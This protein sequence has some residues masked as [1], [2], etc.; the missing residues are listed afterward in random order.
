MF[1]RLFSPESVAVV[2]ASN[3]PVK[4][5][6][7]ILKNLI[8][9][10][11]T[12]KIYP[13][14]RNPGDIQGIHS[15]QSL[16]EINEK[17]D[18]AVITV[19][20]GSVPGEVKECVNLKIPFAVI[21]PGGFSETGE[22][23]KAMEIT[24]RNMIKGSGTRIIGPNTVGVYFP[25]SNL[26]TALTPPERVSFPAAG[27][28][29]FVSQSG[30][31]GL[32]TMDSISEFGIGIS[33]FVNI[34]NKIDLDENELLEYFRND[35][36]TKS[37]A[38]YLESID[39]GR[40]FY[41]LLRKTNRVKPVVVLKSGRTEASAKAASLHTGALASNDMIVNGMIRQ[42]GSA[43]AYDEVELL[44]YSR[45]LAYSKPFAGDR[46]AVVTTAGGVGVITSDYISSERHGIGLRMAAL[47][48]ATRTE[49]RKEIVSFGSAENPV[50]LTADGD[51]SSYEKVLSLL[52][53]DPGVDAIVA[54]ALPQT[55]KMNMDIVEV[56]SRLSNGE[57]PIV[58]GVIGSKLGKEL[59]VE[60]EHARIP[61]YPSIE[62]VV[63]SLKVL[64]EYGR[65]LQ[66]RGLL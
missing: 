42:A 7:A 33:A 52:Q 36:R 56:I 58:A 20:A 50:D 19:P 29:A 4:I 61:A 34:G 45:I 18:L 57:K 5:G 2:G 1:E 60:F 63:K 64:R 11:Y 44:D 65:F 22:S 41:D 49:I 30:A 66:S 9:S 48:E 32:L 6:Y 27:D 24:I 3:N 54:Y 51:I 31:L 59:L 62:R 40:R 53:R 38:L 23:G 55:P 14:N 21:I 35:A 25:Y 17:V 26:N 10:G 37:I 13:V 12:G 15:Y 39:N 16:S 43:R 46:I 8:N 47:S 28:I